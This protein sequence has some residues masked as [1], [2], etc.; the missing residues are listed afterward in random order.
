M[1]Y[2]APEEVLRADLEA[3]LSQMR[4]AVLLEEERP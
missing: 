4:E 2:E 1:E 3:F